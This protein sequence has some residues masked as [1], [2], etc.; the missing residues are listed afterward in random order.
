LAAKT[1]NL[2]R[3]IW[4]QARWRR[5]RKLSAFNYGESGKDVLNRVSTGA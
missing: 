1:Q 5:P 4:A 2:L 3:R